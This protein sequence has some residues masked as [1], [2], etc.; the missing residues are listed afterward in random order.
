MHYFDPSKSGKKFEWKPNDRPRVPEETLHK[1]PVTVKPEAKEHEQFTDDPHARDI[2]RSSSEK[3]VN[4]QSSVSE[5]RCYDKEDKLKE[6]RKSGQKFDWKPNDQPGVPQE[7]LHKTPVTE[8]PGAKEHVQF[9][10]HPHAMDITHSSAEKE[11]NKQ[12]SVSEAGHYDKGDKLKEERKKGTES[13]DLEDN[14]NG[15]SEGCT[16]KIASRKATETKDVLTSHSQDTG[17]M[18]SD[19]FVVV[20]KDHLSGEE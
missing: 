13:E 3:E 12:T 14:G 11:V 10:D 5:M 20:N 16:R 18:N 19:G 2:A 4:K 15:L 8:K 6:E 9:T 1:T 7:T 17:T